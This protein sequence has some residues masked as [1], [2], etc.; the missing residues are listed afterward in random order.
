MK[1]I[2]LLFYLSFILISCENNQPIKCIL[3]APVISSSS[4]VVIGGVLQL[5]SPEYG[6]TYTYNWTGPN[7]FESNLQN[8]TVS[9][10]SNA[11]AGEYKL[12]VSKGICKT[13][14]STLEVEVFED[15]VTCTPPNNRL[16]FNSGSLPDVIFNSIYAIST[17]GSFKFN[18]SGS[19]TDLTIIFAS[20]T[21]PLPGIYTI[22]NS[23]PTSFLNANEVCVSLN[24]SNYFS[25]AH[26]GLVSISYVNG[27]LS[28]T[29][30]EVIFSPSDL[31]FVL[32]T[33]TKIT[34]P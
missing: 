26:E 8:P 20:E 15:P 11:S 32:N 33:S 21:Q 13:I 5:S 29:F 9:N 16:I 4:P 18:A 3:A 30:C 28:A 14:E 27:K 2:Y 19:N 34:Q 6:D 22:G 10:I 25:F 23:C 7:G 24:Y 1:K 17:N 12:S 31:P